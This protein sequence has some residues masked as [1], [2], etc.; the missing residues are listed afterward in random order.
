ME[1]EIEL[2][3]EYDL[4]KD[5]DAEFSEP[6]IVAED[7]EF[8]MPSDWIDHISYNLYVSVAVVDTESDEV[9]AE[10][11]EAMTEIEGKKVVSCTQCPKICKSKGGLTKHTNSKH[12]GVVD[13]PFS[14]TKSAKQETHLSEENLASIVEEIKTKL[15]K[16]DLFGPDINSALKKISSS[17]AVV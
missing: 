4:P 17:K 16:E 2:E 1:S 6:E 14:T 5:E 15:I 11:V 12:R 13:T 8:E 7:V 3:Q 10:F 9:D